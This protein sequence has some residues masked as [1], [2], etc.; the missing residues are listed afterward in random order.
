MNVYRN[1]N[2]DITNKNTQKHE[3]LRTVPEEDEVED[4]Q[5][6]T[7]Y[8][9]ICLNIWRKMCTLNVLFYFFFNSLYRLISLAS[10]NHN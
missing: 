6:S 3:T 1:F 5:F 2:V 10:L 4:S 9:R 8:T 7:E